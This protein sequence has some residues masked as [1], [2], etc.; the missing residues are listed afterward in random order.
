MEK[1]MKDRI[2]ADLLLSIEKAADTLCAK[3][4]IKWFKR[5]GDEI[6]L[7]S[8]TD[9]VYGAQ[10][11][12]RS[13]ISYDREVVVKEQKA[14]DGVAIDVL[15]RK[16]NYSSLTSVAARTENFKNFSIANLQPYEFTLSN[17]AQEITVKTVKKRYR[18]V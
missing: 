13:T 14:E 12:M 1:A 8:K 15:K 2:K 10:V 11:I 18:N 17:G 5:D 7:C 9:V 6:L 3:D 16:I 4:E